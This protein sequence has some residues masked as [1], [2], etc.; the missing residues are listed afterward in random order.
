MYWR[1]Q[2]IRALVSSS[3][4]PPTQIPSGPASRAPRS[5]RFCVHA[6]FP[7]WAPWLCTASQVTREVKHDKLSENVLP[8]QLSMSTRR[9]EVV[10][11]RQGG[12]NAPESQELR[13]D[14]FVLAVSDE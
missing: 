1:V 3:L 9:T 6:Y 14:S 11:T 13:G 2:L 10:T 12:R 4:G 5:V 8:P 7:R